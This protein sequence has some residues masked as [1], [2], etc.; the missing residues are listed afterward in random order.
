M[1]TIAEVVLSARYLLQDTAV[2]YRFSDARLV[3]T[4]NGALRETFRLRPDLFL[5][6]SYVI[7]SYTEAD[8]AALTVFPLEDQWYNAVV[9]FIVG[10]TELSDDEFTLDGRAASLLAA[11][12]RQLTGML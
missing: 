2:P 9:E 8:L 7:P 4:F 6:T 12:K 10:Y 3:G 1:S 11:Y 5:A